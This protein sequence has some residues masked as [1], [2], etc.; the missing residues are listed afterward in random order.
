MPSDLEKFDDDFVPTPSA[1]DMSRAEDLV[2]GAY[3][4]EITGAQLK[5]VKN[6][7]ILEM[8]LLVLTPGPHEGATVQHSLFMN[9]IESAN[10]VGRDLAVL[11]FD[12]D[13]WK[14][15]NGRPFSVEIA[16]AVKLMKGL[17]WQG[18][19]RTNKS[20]DKVYHNIYLDGRVATD[21]HPERF[22]PAE[23]DAAADPD[24]PFGE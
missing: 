13:Q 24:D 1:A 18:T 5:V 12:T 9:N 3:E 19:K 10:R 6:N 8:H 15:P 16:K 22:G 4:F 21:G 20:G 11:G 7:N 23:L 17:R 2:D 14:K